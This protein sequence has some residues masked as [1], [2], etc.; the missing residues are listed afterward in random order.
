MERKIGER[1]K[2]NGVTLE[3]IEHSEGTCNG[4]YF[5]SNN[6]WMMNSFCK[7]IGCCPSARSDSKFVIFK[8]VQQ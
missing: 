1:F 2:Y 8:E 7:N 3:C 5:W 6:F 4:C